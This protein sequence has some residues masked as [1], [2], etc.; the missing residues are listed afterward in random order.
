MHEGL[1][2][3]NGSFGRTAPAWQRNSGMP[4]KTM[5]VLQS[6]SVRFADFHKN[7]TLPIWLA[8]KKRLK[9]DR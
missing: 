6:A 2:K 9:N 5:A 7:P 4:W 1:W 3:Q 8:G